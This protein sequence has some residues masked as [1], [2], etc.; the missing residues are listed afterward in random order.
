MRIEVVAAI[1]SREWS[2]EIDCSTGTAVRE[3]VE[4]AS[5]LAAF[6]DAPL[7]DADGYA[8]W[9]QKIDIDHILSEGDR[10]EVLR[11]L[12]NEPMEMRRSQAKDGAIK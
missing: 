3:A 4:A 2:A 7:E 1:T 9:G 8:V 12:P 5:R 11:R 6:A 10:V